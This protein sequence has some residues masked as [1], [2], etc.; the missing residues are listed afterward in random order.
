MAGEAAQSG[1]DGNSSASYTMS[2]PANC[3]HMRSPVCPPPLLRK[4]ILASFTQFGDG[5][6]WGDL[7]IQC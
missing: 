5:W 4:E 6:Q 7:I 1:M 3:L 2:I